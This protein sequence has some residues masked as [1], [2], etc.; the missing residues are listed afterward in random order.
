MAF[1]NLK[2]LPVG[3]KVRVAEAMDPPDDVTWDDDAGRTSGL[4][5]KRLITSFFKGD[6]RIVGEV[7]YIAKES[8]REK[9]RRKGL[10]KVRLRHQSGSMLTI[11]AAPAVLVGK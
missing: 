1:E 4:L 11:T 5:K 3:A 2:I 7:V 10:V 9:L 6:P 8:E